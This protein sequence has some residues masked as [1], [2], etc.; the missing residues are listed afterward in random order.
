MQD[1]ITNNKN[2]NFAPEGQPHCWVNTG[3]GSLGL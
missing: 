3:G 2:E 1:E